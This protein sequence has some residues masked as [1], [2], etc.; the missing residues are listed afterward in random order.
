[1]S[2][3]NAAAA[4]PASSGSYL[5]GCALVVTGGGVLSLGAICIRAASASTAWQYI[6]W[7]ALGVVAA[8]W[9][10]ARLRGRTS[11]LRQIAMLAPVGWLGASA[12]T[13]AGAAFV[14]ALQVTTLAETF[15]LCSLAPLLV[16]MLA[17]PLLGEPMGL[18]S[19]TAIGVGLI[20]VFVMIGGALE[21]GNAAGRILAL[22][23]MA[24]FA[25]YTLCTRG[26]SARDLDAMLLVYGLMSVVLGAAAIHF[27]ETPLTPR[28]QDVAIAV[29]HG[30][31]LLSGGLFLFGQGS[32][33]V[34]AV[35][36]TVL[37][38]TESALAPLWGYLFFDEQPSL[39][40]VLGGFII[41]GAVILQATAG[42][43]ER[44]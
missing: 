41:I 42:A 14:A 13:A 26:A 39:G 35:T 16:T 9:V 25:A 33:F 32:R 40:T 28:W 15:F 6:F 24:M 20:G 30:A 38:Q 8:L 10:L 27:T 36:L 22:T 34:S 1:M 3:K 7:R 4:A 19:L 37:A 43:P 12:L 18:W 2:E 17:R 31:F 44:R 21:G 11:P 29:L 5:Y 23:S